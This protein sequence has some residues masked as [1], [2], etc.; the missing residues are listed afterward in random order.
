MIG[1]LAPEEIEEVLSRNRIA[2]LAMSLGDRP[3]VVP[4]N[5]GYDGQGLYGFCAFGRKIE[6]M[7]QQPYVAVLVDEITGPHRWRSVMV[8]GVYEELVDPEDHQRAL[9]AWNRGSESGLM[10]TIPTNGSLVVF[11]IRPEH[12]SGRF[13]QSES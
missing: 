3:Y 13:E 1:K 4:I 7:R 5:Y 11:R 10:R 8:E 6:T 12:R 9:G 2:R